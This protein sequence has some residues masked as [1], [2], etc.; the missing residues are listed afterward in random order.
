MS[1]GVSKDDH[2]LHRVLWCSNTSVL[3][4]LYV[5]CP[6]LDKVL[7]FER[8]NQSLSTGPAIALALDNRCGARDGCEQL[9]RRRRA[10]QTGK[11]LALFHGEAFHDEGIELAVLST[12]L[13]ALV[14]RAQ[15][16]QDP[17]DFIG[18]DVIEK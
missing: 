6:R 18:R 16:L 14:L 11:L 15:L 7:L 1:F 9:L 10:D 13:L 3:K 12:A 17:N 5:R 2:D 4:T 8:Q